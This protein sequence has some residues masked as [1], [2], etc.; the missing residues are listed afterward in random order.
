MN[1]TMCVF[2]VCRLGAGRRRTEHRELVCT[3]ATHSHYFG[4]RECPTPL[5]CARGRRA[6]ENHGKFGVA[7]DGRGAVVEQVFEESHRP[8]LAAGLGLRK[9]FRGIGRLSIASAAQGP[10]VSLSGLILARFGDDHD[11]G[12][13]VWS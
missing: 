1:I 10:D 4:H 8:S 9:G 2:E 11:R 12:L 6:F 5:T 13:P 7:G 3:F